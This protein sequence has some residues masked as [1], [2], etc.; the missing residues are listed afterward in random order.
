LVS[1]ILDYVGLIYNVI[2]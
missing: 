1:V 2:N